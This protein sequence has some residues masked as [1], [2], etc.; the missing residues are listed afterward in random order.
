MRGLLRLLFSSRPETPCYLTP[1]IAPIQQAPDQSLSPS[2][3]ALVWR[4]PFL[5]L[6]RKFL[7]PAV[8]ERIVE[9]PWVLRTL[10]AFPGSRVLDFGCSN[11]PLSLEMAAMGHKVVGA[12]LRPYGYTH[13][14]FELIQGDFLRIPTP[15]KYFDVV[16]AVSA[17]EHVGLD[18]VY[19]G[20]THESGDRAIVRKFLEVLKPGGALLLTVPFGLAGE[21]PGYRVYDALGLAALLVG[22]EVREKLFFLGER[23]LEWIEVP[24]SR[25]ADVPSHENGLTQGVALVFAA[26]PA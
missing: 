19:G 20:P 7:T 23:Q 22:F 21:N 11:S 26:K 14:N 2:E 1:I 13:P 25:L 9:L 17:V 8:N 24:E 5:R 15:E 12:D 16:V 10:A 18:G 3:R 6:K 4:I